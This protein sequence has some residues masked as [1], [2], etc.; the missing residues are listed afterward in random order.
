MIRQHPTDDD[1]GPSAKRPRTPIPPEPVVQVAQLPLPLQRPG[2]PAPRNRIVLA[3]DPVT[4]TPAIYRDMNISLGADE[5]VAMSR[6]WAQVRTCVLL[7]NQLMEVRQVR[8][9]ST[10][11]QVSEELREIA[12]E[13][14]NQQRSQF[15]L[16]VGFGTVNQEK[17]S[18]KVLIRYAEKNSR[19]FERQPG[20]PRT[21]SFQSDMDAVMDEFDTHGLAK[22]S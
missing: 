12:R 21:I 10:G 2:R 17:D 22:V 9:Q 19:L 8:L 16:D 4:V 13:I 20:G 11:P 5:A 1:A 6:S 15:R 7:K 18:D 3:D 14:F